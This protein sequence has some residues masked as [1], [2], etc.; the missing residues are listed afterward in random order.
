MVFF[1]MFVFSFKHQHLLFFLI[2]KVKVESRKKDSLENYGYAQRKK[3]HTLFHFHV[4]VSFFPLYV[5][6]CFFSFVYVSTHTHF[7]FFK[8]ES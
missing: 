5:H 1:C 8:T 2:T 3:N 6:N 4:K 7:A